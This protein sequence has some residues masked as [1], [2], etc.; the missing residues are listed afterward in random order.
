MFGD[1]L[2]WESGLWNEFQRMQRELDALFNPLGRTNI[3]AVA[4]GSFPP[5][6]VGSTPEAVHVYAFAPGLDMNTL[7]L[8]IQRSLLTLAGERKGEAQESGPSAGYHL[9]ER[10]NGAFRRVISLPDDV[11]PDRVN[12][13]YRNGVLYVTIAKQEAAKPR[14]IQ[15]SA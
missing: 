15:V 10:F 6:N 5:V 13:T 7:D 9:Q 3:R 8:S 12:A 11:D 2:S 14:Q 1:L 4:W